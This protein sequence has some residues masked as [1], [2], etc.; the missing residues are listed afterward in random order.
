MERVGDDGDAGGDGGPVGGRQVHGQVPQRA[1]MGFEQAFSCRAGA[2]LR[3]AES[4]AGAE[5][6]QVGEPLR[7]GLAADGR[8]AGD[9]AA[10]LVDP[11]GLDWFLVFAQV[12][13]LIVGVLGEREGGGA[14]QDS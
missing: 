5:V 12:S 9:A 4:A 6:D 7:A 10:E 2:F 14:V 3:Q 11:G 13:E 1:F 8:R